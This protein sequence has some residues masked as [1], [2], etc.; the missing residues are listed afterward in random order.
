MIFKRIY[1]AIL[2]LLLFLVIMLGTT[3]FLI[4]IHECQ[5]CGTEISLI[6]FDY[7]LH[8]DE[9]C[10]G[11][12]VKESCCTSNEGE[13]NSSGHSDQCNF[14]SG[15]CCKYVTESYNLNQFLVKKTYVNNA[16]LAIPEVV[17]NILA[18]E[19]IR[20]VTPITSYYNKHCNIHP[21]VMYCCFLT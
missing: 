6:V 1:K 20:S 8:E 14:G 15:T 5:H 18:T 12:P 16:D 9:D 13:K 7:A 2:A 10:Y 17:H 11:E 4:E 3:G 19:Y 21:R